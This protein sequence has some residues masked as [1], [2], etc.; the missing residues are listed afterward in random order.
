[1]NNFNVT[2]K[3][4]RGAEKI[5]RQYLD[6]EANK[7]EQLQK[8]DSKV[9][10]PGKVVASILGVIG[11]LTMGGGMAMIMVNDVMNNGLLLG[12]PGMLIALLAYPIYS[13]ITNSRKKKYAD[14]IIRLSN[15]V[16]IQ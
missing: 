9:K 14:E 7:L 8:L 1:M 3:D 10:A 15:E 4:M 13:L 6:S 12:I 11:S 5:R 2:E 16:V